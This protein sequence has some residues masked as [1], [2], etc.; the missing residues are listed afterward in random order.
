MKDLVEKTI[1]LIKK[2]ETDEVYYLAFSGGKDSIVLLDLTKKSG[3][4]FNAFYNNTTIDP[5]GHI[6]FIKD[7]YPEVKIIQPPKSFYQ[8]V[9]E[10][11]LPTRNKPLCCR[12]LK[13]YSSKG[14]RILEGTRRRESTKRSK[15]EYEECDT[16]KWMKGAVHVR[17]LLNWTEDNIWTYINFYKLSYSKYYDPPYNFKRLGCIGC[18]HASNNRIKQYKLFPKYAKA[19][20]KTI[21]KR[22]DLKPQCSF[23]INFNNEYEVFYWWLSELSISQFIEL[24]DNGLFKIDFKK[25]I[26]EIFNL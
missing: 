1:G 18:P 23:A 7:N 19:I 20:I 3:V 2:L 13:E 17:I 5:P 11:G 16:R 21:K 25:Q 8:I 9:I 24:R 14:K 10:Q 15:Y 4:K 6:K 12:C 22:I 26:I